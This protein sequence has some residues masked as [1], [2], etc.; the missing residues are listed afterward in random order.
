MVGL[1]SLK[2]VIEASVPE[3][4]RLEGIDLILA[5]TISRYRPAGFAATQ[6]EKSE[7]ERCTIISYRDDAYPAHLKKIYDP[8]VLLFVRDAQHILEILN[9]RL[10]SPARPVQ[11]SLKLELTE[12]EMAVYSVLSGDPKYI[13][14]IVAL[15]ELDPSTVL[16]ILLGLELK[17]AVTQLIGKQFTR[18]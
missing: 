17:G 1:G 4:C 2:T 11:R 12:P 10:Y 15:T 5:Q 18:A 9:P 16:T 3:L 14:D 7:K 6:L 8:P 13:D